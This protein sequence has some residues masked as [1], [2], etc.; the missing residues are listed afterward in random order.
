MTSDS[1]KETRKIVDT[2]TGGLPSSRGGGYKELVALRRISGSL[3]PSNL[4]SKIT[5]NLGGRFKLLI[6]KG[7]EQLI[8]YTLLLWRRVN[9]EPLKASLSLR[10]GLPSSSGGG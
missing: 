6:A 1:P 8:L 2:R 10:R 9:L 7:K 5:S 4:L 3:P